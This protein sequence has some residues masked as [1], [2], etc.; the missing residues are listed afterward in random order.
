MSAPI[1]A[2]STGCIDGELLQWWCSPA[3]TL[4][5]RC[6]SR[7]EIML[8][9]RN[10]T[11]SVSAARCRT[12]SSA[13]VRTLSHATA[14]DGRPPCHDPGIRD[15]DSPPTSVAGADD[16]DDVLVDVAGSAR[17]STSSIISRSR[18]SRLSK[19]SMTKANISRSARWAGGVVVVEDGPRSMAVR[20]RRTPFSESFMLSLLLLSVLESSGNSFWCGICCASTR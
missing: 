3:A 15:H 7:D 2:A 16:E 18:R 8:S 17:D 1:V 10:C 11:R 9:C 13:F 19:S 5:S 12:S 4:P 14:T 20:L 6:R